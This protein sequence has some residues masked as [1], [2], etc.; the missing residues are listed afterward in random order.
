MGV[1]LVAS[2]IAPAILS[3][4]MDLQGSVAPQ[5]F[6]WFATIGAVVHFA[7]GVAIFILRGPLAAMLS[8]A[9]EAAE[10][11]NGTGGAQAAA[12]AVIGVFFFANG[13]HAFLADE[14]ENSHHMFQRTTRPWVEMAVGAALFLGARGIVVVW[15][16]L[17]TAG[18]S[19]E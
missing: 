12:I 13:L 15:Q 4:A 17:R 1:Y 16:K 14:L 19:T 6:R 9:T 11:G 3:V 18:R 5:Q 10:E 7:C 8:P 2:N